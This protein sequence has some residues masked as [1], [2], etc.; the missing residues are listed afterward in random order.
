MWTICHPTQRCR[1][2]STDEVGLFTLTDKGL[3]PMLDPAAFLKDRRIGGA[4][5][6]AGIVM[7]GNRAV[8][9]EVQVHTSRKGPLWSVH[10]M[11]HYVMQSCV[12]SCLAIAGHMALQN[13]S[14]FSTMD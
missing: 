12:Q 7:E 13:V 4:A 6:A 3:Q 9:V 1:F 2:G 5:C 11:T 14:W 8:L 10:R